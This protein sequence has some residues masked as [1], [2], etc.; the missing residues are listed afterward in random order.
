MLGVPSVFASSL[1]L[2]YLDY[3]EK[4]YQLVYQVEVSRALEHAEMLLQ[5]P[6]SKD[7]WDT[8]RR[9]MLDDTVDVNRFMIELVENTIPES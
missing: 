3:L 4:E 9:A 7:T 1:R 8:R 6:A 5:N 2:R